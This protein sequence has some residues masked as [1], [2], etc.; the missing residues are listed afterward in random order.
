MGYALAAAARAAGHKVELIS[1]PVCLPPPRGVKLIP[2]ITADEMFAAVHSSF[3]HADV[4]VMCAAVADY[5]AARMSRR[6]I[7]KKTEEFSL[8]LKPTRDIL[9]SLPRRRDCF[10]VGFAAETNDLARHARA[11]LARK[12]CEMVIANDVSHAEIG[13]ESDENAVTIFQREGRTRVLKRAPKKEIARELVKII[14]RE[15]Q[16]SFDKK[17]LRM[18]DSDT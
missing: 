8:V 4:L 3:P 16:K 15:V 10:V 7:K 11:K 9:L 13:M 12:N 6:K 2:V 5:Q 18:N 17:M 1:G 14:L